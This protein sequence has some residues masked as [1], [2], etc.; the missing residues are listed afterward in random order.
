MP[1]SAAGGLFTSAFTGEDSST[2]PWETQG[3][4]GKPLSG[5]E[6]EYR[7]AP[8][9]ERPFLLF[10]RNGSPAQHRDLEQ[11]AME[12]LQEGRGHGP[13]DTENEN[14][15]AAPSFNSQAKVREWRNEQPFSFPF[16]YGNRVYNQL[17]QADSPSRPTQQLQLEQAQPQGWG[18][19]CKNPEDPIAMRDFHI[20]VYGGAAKKAADKHGVPA[21]VLLAIAEQE[22]RG[23]PPRFTIG[24]G[25]GVT[26]VQRN[27]YLQY[28]KDTGQVSN[29][30]FVREAK[31][32]KSSKQPFS[33]QWLEDKYYNDVT[34]YD[35]S[36]DIT[37]HFLKKLTDKYGENEAIRM[38]NQGEDYKG[39]DPSLNNPK[40]V[41]ANDYYVGVSHRVDKYR[42]QI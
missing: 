41:K 26:Q 15:S 19:S 25:N 24:G 7:N 10:Q 35:S 32:V 12:L 42:G 6:D 29:D 9:N 39:A 21:E 28:L 36:F 3:P 11:A 4:A 23:G 2:P 30:D 14:D 13:Y 5:Y 8:V 20:G 34:G 33:A 18:S 31:I 38:Y 37:G 1:R 27:N 22:K 17:S 16:P 40:V